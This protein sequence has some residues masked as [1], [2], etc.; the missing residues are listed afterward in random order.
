MCNFL[1]TCSFHN[2]APCNIEFLLNYLLLSFFS[3]GVPSSDWIIRKIIF[4]VVKAQC[5]F[6]HNSDTTLYE[7]VLTYRSMDLKDKRAL[8]IQFP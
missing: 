6:E 5:Y 1:P 2:T 8:I 7:K 4:K 3:N